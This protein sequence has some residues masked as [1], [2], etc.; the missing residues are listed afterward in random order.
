MENEES[1]I[2]LSTVLSPE[3]A[4]KAQSVINKGRIQCRMC[5][6]GTLDRTIKRAGTQKIKDITSFKDVLSSLRQFLAT[7][8]PLKTMKNVFYFTLKTLLVL[9]I[10]KLWS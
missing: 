6:T 9:R 5:F 4:L 2:N 3:P 10:Y 1:C 7:E 8:R